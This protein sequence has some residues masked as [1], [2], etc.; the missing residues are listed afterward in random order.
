MAGVAKGG[1]V[2]VSGSHSIA[3]ELIFVECVCG[4]MGVL[5][6]GRYL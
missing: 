2:Y 5:G 3:W 1:F 6:M 4:C